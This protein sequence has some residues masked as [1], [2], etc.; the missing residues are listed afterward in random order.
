MHV[1]TWLFSFSLPFRSFHLRTVNSQI[2]RTGGL[3]QGVAIEINSQL[4]RLSFSDHHDLGF[5]LVDS[6]LV[7]F[8]NLIQLRHDDLK[9]AVLAIIV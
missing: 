2:I 7:L 8:H 9:S 5:A 6:H 3:I 4:L 1:L